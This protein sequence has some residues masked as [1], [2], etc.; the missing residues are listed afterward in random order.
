MKDGTELSTS[1]WR[2]ETDEPVPALLVRTP[3][4]KETG[5]LGP[6]SPALSALL[7]G[8]YAV[9]LQD[10]RGTFASAGVFVPHVHDAADGADTVAW[11]AAQEW[12]DGSVGMLGASYVGM[13]QW[14]AAASGAPELKAIAPAVTSADLYRAPWHSPGGALS[15][16]GALGWATMMS[17][18]EARR[19]LAQGRDVAEDIAALAARLAD[20]SIHNEATPVIDQPLLSAHLPWTVDVGIGHP[21]RDET[22]REISALDQV[23]SITTP[24][25]HIGGWYDLFIGQ[26]LRSYGEMKTRAGTTEAREGQRLV[27]GPWSH[28]LSGFLGY[29]PDRDFGITAGMDAAA[30]AEPHIAF[31]DR[32]LKGRQEGL[33]GRLPVRLFVMGIDRWRDEPDWPLPGTD[34]TAY[35]LEGDGPANSAAGAG[36]LT[37]TQPA[38]AFVDTYL[39]DPRRPVPSF[40]GTMMNTGGY[41]GPADQR[42]VHDRDDVLV[43]TTD[44]LD[45]PVEVTGPVSARLFVSSSAVDT[46]FTAK[47]VDVHP[48]GRAIILC[49]GIQRMRYRDSLADPEPVIPGEVYEIGIDLIAT[50][51]VFLPGHRIMVEVSSSNFPRYD[52]NS[53]TGG[54]IAREH[55]SDMVAAVNRIHRGAEYPSR[56]VLPVIHR[57]PARPGAAAAVQF[58]P[59]APVT[60]PGSRRTGKPRSR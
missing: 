10:C 43:F 5:G 51:T 6:S 9:A 38:D 20:R 22:W 48:D 36:R 7:R 50:S 45:E 41:D 54:V 55:L 26:T 1:I 25:L 44:V 60:D 16:D 35:Y 46:D 14:L 49:D 31:F 57:Q 39:Y 56:V 58:G 27:I 52:R 40:G 17:L 47:L 24:A 29:F 11:L 37:T 42:P 28:N 4:D 3:Y 8:G 34:Y 12:C 23:S 32:W 19:A 59:G 13:V 53:N 33:D 18:N 30:L 15:L 21:D 2:P